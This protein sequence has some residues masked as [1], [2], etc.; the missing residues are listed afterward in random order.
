MFVLCAARLGSMVKCQNDPV[1]DDGYCIP[2]HAKN[3]RLKRTYGI[4]LSQA[5]FILDEQQWICPVCLH[6]ILEEWVVDHDHRVNVRIVRGILTPN[7]NHR[8]VGRH[9]DGNLL[10]RAGK[11]LNDPPGPRALGAGPTVPKRHRKPRKK[12]MPA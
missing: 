11:Y 3:L 4:S 8:V 1:F 2:H 9:T 7:C 5:E 12:I 10:I 6:P